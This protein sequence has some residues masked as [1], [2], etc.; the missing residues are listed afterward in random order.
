MST[1]ELRLKYTI[2]Y[3][4]SQGAAVVISSIPSLKLKSKETLKILEA[5]PDT[6]VPIE[7]KVMNS[8]GNMPPSPIKQPYKAALD[9]AENIFKKI[10]QIIPVVPFQY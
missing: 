6:P 2:V 9:A 7:K 1:I 10:K 3:L 8:F 4:N 5:I